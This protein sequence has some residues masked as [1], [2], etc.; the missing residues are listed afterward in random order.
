MGQKENDL[1]REVHD[2]MYAGTERLRPGNTT[3]DGKPKRRR[4]SSWS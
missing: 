4:K 2:S 1:Y 3:A